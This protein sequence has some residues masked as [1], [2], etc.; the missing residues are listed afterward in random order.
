MVYK[1]S[2]CGSEKL[3]KSSY[4]CIGHRGPAEARIHVS[5]PIEKRLIDLLTS[6]RSE[7]DIPIESARVCTDCGNV[8]P[9]VD[10]NILNL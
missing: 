7:N 5:K 10:V 2:C 9:Y 8:M 4:K 1:C 3:I 6:P